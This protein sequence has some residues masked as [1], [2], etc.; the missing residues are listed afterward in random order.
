MS[1]KFMCWVRW[2]F[3]HN[4][5]NFGKEKQKNREKKKK[6]L[7]GDDEIIQT[8]TYKFLITNEIFLL[9][10]KKTFSSFSRTRVAD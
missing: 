1:P 7:F 9:F 4:P 8:K 6:K 2:C 10:V 3:A 5:I